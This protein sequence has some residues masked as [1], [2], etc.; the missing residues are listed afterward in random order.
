MR[1]P[2]KVS[3]GSEGVALHCEGADARGRVFP[4][5]AFRF[6]C[7]EPWVGARPPAGVAPGASLGK[8]AGPA[9]IPKR[10]LSLTQMPGSGF[11]EGL[12]FAFPKV[13]TFFVI[14]API[15]SADSARACRR[16]AGDAHTLRCCTLSAGEGARMSLCFARG[17]RPGP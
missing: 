12:K 17:S 15:P 8:G 9:E 16:S 10:A 7:W 3:R 5:S 14:S 13:G 6:A 11:F 2:L 1:K 4:W